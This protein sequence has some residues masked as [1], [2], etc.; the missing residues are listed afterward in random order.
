MTLTH[1]QS[2]KLQEYTAG[3][4]YGKGTPKG[5]WP[6]PLSG[7]LPL[8]FQVGDT[9][10][11][12]Q[13]LL[14]LLHAKQHKAMSVCVACSGLTGEQRGAC[15]KVTQTMCHMCSC[16]QDEAYEMHPLVKLSVICWAEETKVCNM[17]SHTA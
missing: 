10:C 13:H 14:H 15:L 1:S 17:M 6:G 8:P 3:L 4:A 7:H 9:G 5:P 12:E 16:S 11:Q 2:S